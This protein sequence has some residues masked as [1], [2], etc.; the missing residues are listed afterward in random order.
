[1]INGSVNVIDIQSYD[2]LT[3]NFKYHKLINLKL[4]R[5]N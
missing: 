4:G 2:R 1:M 3:G 5:R